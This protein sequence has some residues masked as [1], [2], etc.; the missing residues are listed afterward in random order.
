MIFG[1][2]LDLSGDS[3]DAL[4]NCDQLSACNPGLY[5]VDAARAPGCRAGSDGCCTPFCDPYR[6]PICPQEM[7]DAG[8]ECV[9]LAP[10]APG[11][12]IDDPGA[13]L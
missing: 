13:C 4:D 11:A 1:C 3:G 5:C 7:I 12:G 8:A 2:L 9:P 6:E 10:D